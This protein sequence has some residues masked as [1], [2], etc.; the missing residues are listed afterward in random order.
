M[1]EPKEH[2]LTDMVSM[3]KD[4]NIKDDVHSILGAH[5]QGLQT[6]GDVNAFMM[7][8][9]KSLGPGIVDGVKEKLRSEVKDKKK[10]QELMR[11]LKEAQIDS[12]PKPKH[13]GKATG[14]DGATKNG[15]R[16]PPDTLIVLSNG[17]SK[18]QREPT[19]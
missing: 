11:A 4:T 7:L 16:P 13:K 3:M 9:A 19:K 18:A 6:W 2:S 17:K 15:K 8:N 12:I 10:V 5:G 14:F 1:A